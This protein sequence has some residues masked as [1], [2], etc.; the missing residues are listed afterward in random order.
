M[1]VINKYEHNKL[2]VESWFRGFWGNPAD[3]S[4]IERYLASDAE[5][6]YP[7][8]ETLCSHQSIQQFMLAF[9][10]AYPNLQFWQVGEL[11][12]EGDY[13]IGRWDGMATHTGSAFDDPLVGVPY[14]N[15]GMS[16]RFTGGNIRFYLVDGK[17]KQERAQGQALV[18]LQ[19]DSVDWFR[20]PLHAY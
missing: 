12:A 7:G 5:L 3:L 4:V 13:I 1:S 17:I 20:Q 9:R 16:I 8:R 11:I 15:S 18:A 2:V 19:P 6:I 14:A 10:R